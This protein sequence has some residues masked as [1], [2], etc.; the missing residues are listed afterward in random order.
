MVVQA[1]FDIVPW[2]SATSFGCG[3]NGLSC[4]WIKRASAER[5]V[6]V[7]RLAQGRAGLAQRQANCGRASV[8]RRNRAPVT[9][10]ASRMACTTCSS[11]P[12]ILI[13]GNGAAAGSVKGSSEKATL[14]CR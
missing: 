12:A 11:V 4:C 13:G 9:D 3:L 1:R 7:E 10:R 8:P 5:K 14:R 6:G 2:D